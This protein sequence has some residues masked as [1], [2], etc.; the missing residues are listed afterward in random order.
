MRNDHAVIALRDSTGR[1]WPTF[2]RGRADSEEFPEITLQI[3][4]RD[5]TRSNVTITYQGRT[6]QKPGQHSIRNA[7]PTARGSLDL[8]GV[9]TATR[10][11]LGLA[12][13]NSAE[14]RE[15][16]VIEWWAPARPAAGNA[17]AAPRAQRNQPA[18][19]PVPAAPA[20]PAAPATHAVDRNALRNWTDSQGRTIEARLIRTQDDQ[21]TIQRADGQ[22]F[23]I[24][25]STLSPADQNFLR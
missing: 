19:T 7:R 22:E 17:P 12:P 10:G 14:A 20:R 8:R 3:E 9:V 11:E 18:P 2:Y 21:V 16:I 15:E 25:R 23:T 4:L 5:A 24:P 6:V 13:P 1:Q